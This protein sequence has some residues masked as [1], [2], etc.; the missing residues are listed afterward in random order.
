MEL[1]ENNHFAHYF[2]GGTLAILHAQLIERWGGTYSAADF[3]KGIDHL[4]R[5]LELNPTIQPGQM[6]L[7]W[8]YT[9][10]GQYDMA[11]P[12]LDKAVQ[13]E[14]ALRAKGFQ[15]VGGQTLRGNLLF[16]LRQLDDARDAYNKSMSTLE[17]SQHVY[18]NSF[19]AQTHCGLGD[20]AYVAGNFD[21][22]LK[23]Y[24]KAVEV[25][26]AAPTNSG[27]GFFYVRGCAGMAKAFDSLGVPPQASERI[28]LARTTLENKD[29]FN[30]FWTW[31]GCDAQ[32]YYDLASA[33][34]ELHQTD[35]A[36]ECLRKAAVDLGWRDL[37]QSV[38]SLESLEGGDSISDLLDDPR[39]REVVEHVRRTP[40]LT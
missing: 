18:K 17:K 32:A 23:H 11:M 21:E 12:Y 36:I 4:K 15:F 5:S 2:Y 22:A 20:L 19:L 40:P 28:E 37:Q 29:G 35:N 30:F 13:L 24:G 34:A 16:R 39:V 27:I 33:Y 31:D 8:F 3:Q 1:E 6:F 7:G 10:H 9:L 25:A 14:E 38:I 26:E